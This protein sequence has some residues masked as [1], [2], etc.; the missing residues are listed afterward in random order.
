MMAFNLYLLIYSFIL[1]PIFCFNL[2]SRRSQ[3]FQLARRT[4][5]ASITIPDRDPRLEFNLGKIAFSLLPFSPES[6]GRRKTILTEIVANQVWTLDQLQGVIN[7]NVPVRSTIIKLESGG[8][9]INNPVAPTRECV[10][11]VRELE[12][13]HGKV[14]HIILSTLGVEHKGTV[15]V[16][17]TYFPSAEIWIQPGQY[18]FPINLP[19][20]FFFPLFKTL[21]EIPPSSTE[22]PWG[23]DIDHRILGPFFSRQG[24]G[25]GETAFFHKASQS[26]IVTDSIVK[27]EDEPPA[28]VQEDPRALL[29]HARDKMTDVVDDTI[30]N[31]LK[32]WRRMVL[33]ALT[34]QP[35]GIVISDL[36]DAIKLLP[37]VTTEMK[38]LGRGSIPIDEGLYPVR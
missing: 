36:F 26:L 14:K 3:E 1:V 21:K 29:Y 23:N 19:P 10:S 24:G 8:L 16:F 32:G 11:I 37:N 35:A 27:V 31:R 22:A 28:I 12:K 9:W 38:K 5:A 18:A 33:F 17:S 4:N 2:K 15:G 20:S 7:V 13:S 30:S 25:Y 6:M 34:F